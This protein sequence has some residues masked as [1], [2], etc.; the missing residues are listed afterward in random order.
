MMTEANC[1]EEIGTIVLKAPIA[2]WFNELDEWRELQIG[3]PSRPASIRWIVHQFSLLK[4]RT[5]GRSRAEQAK[6]ARRPEGQEESVK[7]PSRSVCSS[8]TVAQAEPLPV[9]KPIGPGRVMPA[10]LLFVGGIC[11]PSQGAQDAI[12]KSPSGNCPHGWL[13]SGAYCVRSG[14]R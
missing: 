4:H 7:T 14:G 1:D 12:P 9:P 13:T 8:V 2:A 10:W 5:A 6:A 3:K 11:S